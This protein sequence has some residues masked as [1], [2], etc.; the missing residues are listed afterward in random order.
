MKLLRRVHKFCRF[1]FPMLINGIWVSRIQLV[2]L[3]I[4]IAVLSVG[5]G[6]ELSL[7]VQIDQGL[8][9]FL[10][11]LAVSLFAVQL[12][13]WA[14]ISIVLAPQRAEILET[15][16]RFG[17]PLYARI[18]QD[19]A[20][21]IAPAYGV[22]MCLFVSYQFFRIGE[23]TAALS[24]AFTNILIVIYLTIVLSTRQDQAAVKPVFGGSPIGS[25]LRVM[26][27]GERLSSISFVKRAFLIGSLVYSVAAYIVW[28]ILPQSAAFLVGA[29]GS[30]FVA[31]S[32]IA[33]WL[34]F[35][36]FLLLGSR[37]PI[38]TIVILLPFLAETIYGWIG[39]RSGSHAVRA[40]ESGGD[41]K[42]TAFARPT[43]GESIEVW[44]A[45]SDRSN[46]NKPIVFVTAAGGGIRAA[47]WTAAVLG[48]LA[49]CIP[50]F[51]ER[52]FSLSSVSGGSLGAAAFVSLLADPAKAPTL[53]R[54]NH[55]VMVDNQVLKGPHQSFLEEVTATDFLAPVVRQMLLGDLPRSLI[56]WS[57]RTDVLD[58]GIALEVAWERAWRSVCETHYSLEKCRNGISLE[59]QFSRLVARNR[60]LPLIFLN[61]VHQET[62]KRL[63]TATAQIRD[64]EIIDAF[65]F[66]NLVKHDVRISTAILNSARFPIITPSGTLLRRDTD[67]NGNIVTR[68]AGHVIDGGYFDNNG[69]LTSYE[70][71]KSV[72][73]SV[74]GG[75]LSEGSCNNRSRAR[76]VVFIEILNDTTLSDYDIVR[77]SG[78]VPANLNEDQQSFKSFD[79][80][81]PARPLITAIQGLEKTSS[82][83]AV[84]A[85]KSLNRFARTETCDTEFV[86]F[87][88]CPG[89]LPAPALGWT[90]SRESRNAI[91]ELLLG[92]GKLTAKYYGRQDMSRFIDCY[93]QIQDDLGFLV[94]LLS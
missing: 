74:S 51:R 55:P 10:S 18:R 46:A 84:H 85:S 66:F 69:T 43:L 45:S 13:V 27:A 30:A 2:A 31:L 7:S 41:V 80:N 35:G 40:I 68:S 42:G 9:T 64:N 4:V 21:I 16:I 63:I 5:Q 22:T 44:Q 1:L 23:A 47:Y 83:R 28:Y 86:Q 52:V 90:L 33:P 67:R 53:F 94:R 61:G 20:D 36:C 12:W 11:V 92:A 8:S 37:I 78:E 26:F 87:R 38:V 14:N 59:T 82:A 88:L 81:L 89:I 3:L 29:F 60:W 71:A 91:D 56:P 50:N 75:S 25:A 77:R 73:P 32:I 76:K 19:V 24:L 57:G 15:R 48:R 62:G 39:L 54:C 17:S 34:F 49:D 58:R 79:V 70:V 6:K 65:D 93:G 72:L